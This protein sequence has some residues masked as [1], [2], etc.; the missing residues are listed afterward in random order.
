MMKSTKNQAMRDLLLEL[1]VARMDALRNELKI[2]GDID[3]NQYIL[4]FELF[5]ELAPDEAILEVEKAM[6][7]KGLIQSTTAIL[8]A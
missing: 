4:L 6:N 8:K 7:D 5:L 1:V 2:S 3:S